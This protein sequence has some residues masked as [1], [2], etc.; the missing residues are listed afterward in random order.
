MRKSGQIFDTYKLF[1][2]FFSPR[3]LFSHFSP[4]FSVQF[5][6][7]YCWNVSKNSLKTSSRIANNYQIYFFFERRLFHNPDA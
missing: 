3:N 5:F 1:L 7:R 2:D 4:D 6:M